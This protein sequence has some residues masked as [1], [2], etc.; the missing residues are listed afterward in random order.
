MGRRL[1]N[2]K[3]VYGCQIHFKGRHF[4]LNPPIADFD[5]RFAAGG[6]PNCIRTDLGITTRPG[7]SKHFHMTEEE[8]RRK[9]KSLSLP[10][11]GGLYT[12][13]KH[14]F[15]AEVTC[16]TGKLSFFRS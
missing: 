16:L 1:N 5:L 7:L 10:A 6:Y 8:G 12:I 11:T 14:R 15:V 3:I 9:R 4:E 13:V 2:G